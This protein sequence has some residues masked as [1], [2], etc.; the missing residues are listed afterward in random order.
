[1]IGNMRTV[2]MLVAWI[3]GLVVLA[4]TN[5]NAEELWRCVQQKGGTNNGG[6]EK[7]QYV[8]ESSPIRSDPS[9]TCTLGSLPTIGKYRTA[10]VT[11]LAPP[12]ESGETRPSRQEDSWWSRL[13]GLFLRK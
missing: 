1:M 4:A 5:A 9:W 2:V 3:V 10:D 11:A 8:S 6:Q 12:K 7:V 13:K